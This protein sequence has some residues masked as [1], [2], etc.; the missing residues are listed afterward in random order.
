MAPYSLIIG[1]KNYS[2][3]S[4][5]PWLM[6]KATGIEFEETVIA[7]DTSNTRQ[8]ILRHSPTGKVPVLKD[9]ELTVWDS[10]SIG[11]YLNEKHP[12]AGLWPDD[13]IARARAR[14]V[15]AEMHSGFQALRQNMPMNVRSSFPGMGRGPGVQED[16]NRITAIWR[17][18]RRRVTDPADGPYLFGRFTIADAMVAPVVS[19]FR[20]YAVELAD[21]AAAYADAV[22]ENAAVKAWVDDAKKEPMVIDRH[23]F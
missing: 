1:N 16:I 22:W 20:T 12:E 14:S 11:E 17:N 5:R 13:P 7:L 10:L 23:E 9:G 8:E 3:W 18:H 19:R 6:M 4:M 21:E 2:S 15:S